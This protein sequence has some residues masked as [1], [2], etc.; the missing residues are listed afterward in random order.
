MCLYK[1]TN[2]T[3]CGKW[4]LEK[5]NHN[6]APELVAYALTRGASH[7]SLSLIAIA[8]AEPASLRRMMQCINLS[9]CCQW[10]LCKLVYNL[11][12]FANYT[13][14]GKSWLEKRGCSIV[15]HLWLYLQRLETKKLCP[16]RWLTWL[17]LCIGV[18]RASGRGSFSPVATF[19]KLCS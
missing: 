14:R 12:E 7:D 9:E 8:C 17:K 10:V 16:D 15:A 13:A 11:Y 4:Q 19:L 3:A 6:R 1:F 18:F 5:K 2:Y